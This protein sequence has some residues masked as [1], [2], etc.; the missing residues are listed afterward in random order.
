MVAKPSIHHYTSVFI[1]AQPNTQSFAAMQAPFSCMKPAQ[2]VNV[3]QM[4]S[5]VAV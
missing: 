2:A 5:L 4:L 1:A 3:K